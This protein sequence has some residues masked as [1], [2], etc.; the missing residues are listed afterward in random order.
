[1]PLKRTAA[2]A[3][4]GFV[5]LGG[6]ATAFAATQRPAS[7]IGDPVSTDAVVPVPANLGDLGGLGT[8]MGDITVDPDT[9]ALTG[10]G[11]TL[12][13]PTTAPDGSATFSGT[14]PDGRPH[15][16]TITPGLDGSWPTVT[17]DG[18]D[19]RTM[20]DE[21]LAQNPGLRMPDVPVP[22]GRPSITI[23]PEVRDY[24]DRAREALE[25]AFGGSLP[26]WPGRR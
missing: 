2:L 3:V 11:F 7:P 19:L 12:Q 9:G 16:A 20:I 22:P 4:A 10:P 21:F 5:V 24:M 15:T 26:A 14:G 8:A 13:P 25:D 18:R 17:V 1:M 6:G 23:P